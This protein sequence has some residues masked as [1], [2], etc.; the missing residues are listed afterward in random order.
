[1]VTVLK[2]DTVIVDGV[3]HI[4]T[5]AFLGLSTDSYKP[6]WFRGNLAT[7]RCVPY[8]TYQR[9]ST[10][11]DAIVVPNASSFYEMDTGKTYLFGRP[12]GSSDSTKGAWYLQGDTYTQ[13]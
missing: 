8:E 11:P 1:M 10:D 2:G 5:Y 7:G 12:W 9:A 13:T 6:Y 4:V 3:E